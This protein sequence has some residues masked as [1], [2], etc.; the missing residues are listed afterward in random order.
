MYEAYK[1]VKSNRGAAGVDGQT[2]EMF[3]RDLAGNLT[4]SGIADKIWNRM[5]SGVLTFRPRA[6]RL[7][8]KK[9][10]GQ[11]I[12]GVPTV[13]DRIAQMVVKQAI[14]PIRNRS[15]CRTPAGY[16]PGKSA[17][18]AVGVTRQRR[19]G[20]M[21]GSWSSD[22]KGLFDNLPHDL[23][24]KAVRKNVQRKWALLYIQRWL[25]APMEK[26]GERIEPDTRH[27]AQGCVI[28]PIY[29][30]LFLHYAF[31]LWMARTHP[32]L[33]CVGTRMTD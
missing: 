28:S 21:T 15:S 4:R 9:T 11:R 26:D 24:L 1:A 31:D 7:H 19:A 5:S 16:R 29:P 14:E 2:L 3:E 27:P 20:S 12:L 25:T 8:S 6:R 30:N 18:D 22:I 13:S 17:L 23:L 32:D 33:P 10:G